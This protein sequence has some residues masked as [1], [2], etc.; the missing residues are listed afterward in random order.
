MT[1][2]IAGEK[3]GKSNFPVYVSNL[4]KYQMKCEPKINEV[5]R[6]QPATREE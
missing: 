6:N 4:L 5:R 1:E 2:N 3:W